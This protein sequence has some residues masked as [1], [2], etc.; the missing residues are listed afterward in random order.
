MVMETGPIGSIPM[1]RVG[2]ED[3]IPCEDI[4]PE[5]GVDMPGSGIKPIR[6]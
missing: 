1:S 6:G 4:A 3:L 2:N 5:A